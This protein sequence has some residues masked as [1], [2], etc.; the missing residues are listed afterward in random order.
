MAE[1]GPRLVEGGGSERSVRAETARLSIE[2]I[3]AAKSTSRFRWP[4][5]RAVKIRSG[6][7][8]EASRGRRLYGRHLR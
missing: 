1:E 2:A 3:S 5:E 8:Q 7:I 4:A 6:L